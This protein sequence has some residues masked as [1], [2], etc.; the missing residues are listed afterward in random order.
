VEVDARD[1]AQE[2][3]L[4]K[5]ARSWS[6]EGVRLLLE[7]GKADAN[8]VNCKGRTPLHRVFEAHQTTFSTQKC[9]GRFAWK[10]EVVREL[11]KADGIIVSMADSEGFTPLHLAM[12]KEESAAVD[13]LLDTG[14]VDIDVR[15]HSGVTP[16]QRAAACG[17]V[18]NLRK[19]G[20]RG[21]MNPGSEEDLTLINMATEKEAEVDAMHKRRWV[22]HEWRQV[23]KYGGL[24]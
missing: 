15:N 16:A 6:A 7:N 21:L 17:T 4:H 8:A 3:P 11:L 10:G 2:T 19:L 20:E 13:M 12:E 23:K 24:L 14:K 9:N 22:E 18:T 5:A 1:H